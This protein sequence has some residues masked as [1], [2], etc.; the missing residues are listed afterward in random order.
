MLATEFRP[1]STLHAVTVIAI[2]LVA[3]GL[4]WQGRKRGSEWL[5]VRILGALFL[6]GW[7]VYH[8]WK[9]M[10]PQLK[11]AET[12]PLQMC[13]LVALFSA[14]YLATGFRGVL[15]LIYFWGVALCTQAFI[16]PTLTEGPADMGFWHFWISHGIIAVAAVYALAAERYVPTWRDYR[17]AVVAA[18]IYALAVIPV[19]LL[20]DA[21]Y[22]FIGAAKPEQPTLIDVL[23]PWPERIA[24]MVP[25]VA[26]AMALLMVPW[27]LTRRSGLRRARATSGS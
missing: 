25:L 16:T 22:G 23:G 13:H 12:L 27:S 3:I 20:L 7:I 15:P 5:G 9:A 11:P 26:A 14:V 19:N 4:A 8:V 18:A 21:N 10:P 24:L 2:A 6:I 17:I 1:F